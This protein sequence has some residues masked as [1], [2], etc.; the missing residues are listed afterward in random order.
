MGVAL[1]DKARYADSD[2]YEKDNHR[3]DAW[4]YRDWVVNAINQ[5]MPFDNLRSSNLLETCF[6]E[7]LGAVSLPRHFIG[8]H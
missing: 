7:R 4:P 5:D 3:P 1:V 6:P 2:G 8:R